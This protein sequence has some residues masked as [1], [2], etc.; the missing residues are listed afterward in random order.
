MEK[1][2]VLFDLRLQR[3]F[4][5]YLNKGIEVNS[6]VAGTGLWG[7]T[8]WDQILTPLLISW[9]TLNKLSNNLLH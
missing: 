5:H 1:Q 9:V 8:D 3:L 7:L 4:L 2:K 6:K